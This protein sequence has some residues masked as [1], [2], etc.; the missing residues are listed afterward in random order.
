MSEFELLEAI[1][2]RKRWVE[3][4]IASINDP[5]ATIDLKRFLGELDRDQTAL[6][7]KLYPKPVTIPEPEPT[8]EVFP[9]FEIPTEPEPEPEPEVKLP[10]KPRPKRK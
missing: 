5:A 6:E 7:A 8:P 2:T 4:R 1:K 10:R 9:E 3:S